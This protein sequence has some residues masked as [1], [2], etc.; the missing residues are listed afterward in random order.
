MHFNNKD[1]RVLL[2]NLGLV[3][4]LG[5]TKLGNR[6]GQIFVSFE[7]NH[8]FTTT[9]PV[10]TSLHPKVLNGKS[11]NV[12]SVNPIPST[13]HAFLDGRSLKHNSSLKVLIEFVP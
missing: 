4:R 3:N 11:L 5:S 10:N 1:K 8:T 6:N 7:R 2:R 12:W 9:K 13:L